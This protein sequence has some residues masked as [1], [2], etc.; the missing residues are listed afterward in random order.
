MDNAHAKFENY[1]Y[2]K[3]TPEKTM[4]IF[5]LVFT[6]LILTSCAETANK[7]SVINQKQENKTKPSLEKTTKD[8]NTQ[9]KAL[10][11][12]ALNIIF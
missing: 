8:T 4:R 7:T 3:T 2:Y 9:N 10:F 6:L 11:R 1:L 12:L 5:V